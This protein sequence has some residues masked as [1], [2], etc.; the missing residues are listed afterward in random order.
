MR[1]YKFSY[2]VNKEP[3][4]ITRVLIR[5]KEEIL[6]VLQLLKDRKLEN[7]KKGNEHSLAYYSIYESLYDSFIENIRK[8]PIMTIADPWWY[9]AIEESQEGIELKASLL[10]KLSFR[11]G[12]DGEAYFRG[13]ST[14]AGYVVAQLSLRKLTVEEYAEKY[15]VEPV[16]VRQW[17]RRGKLRS[18]NKIGNEWRIPELTDIPKRGYESGMYSISSEYQTKRNEIKSPYDFLKI[19]NRIYIIQDK[20]DKNKY[21]VIYDTDY[22]NDQHSLEMNSNE[23]EKLELFLISTPYYQDAGR[24]TSVSSYET[25]TGY[26]LFGYL[27][28]KVSVED[29]EKTGPG[30]EAENKS[31]LDMELD[32]FFMDDDKVY[33]KLG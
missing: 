5:N 25:I 20:Q 12:D 26:S 4:F 13:Y 14:G 7:L 27:N 16:T 9:Y 3:E 29:L 32:G 22:D 18:A 10:S 8:I 15:D 33:F 1:G 31:D 23:R 30:I 2:K 28:E 11:I 6:K 24:S 19:A 21:I 17:I